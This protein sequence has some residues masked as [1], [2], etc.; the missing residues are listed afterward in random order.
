MPIEEKPW[1]S[2]HVE[3]IQMFA[4]Q[5]EARIKKGNSRSGSKITKL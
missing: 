2:M 4:P 3:R 5:A 1:K